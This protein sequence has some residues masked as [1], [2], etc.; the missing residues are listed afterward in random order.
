MNPAPQNPLANAAD[1]S[2]V[3]ATLRLIASLPA[4]QGLEDRIMTTLHAAPCTAR[5]LRWPAQLRQSSG[6]TRA[7]SAAAIVLVVAGVGWGIGSHI[8]PPQP[9]ARGVVAP[10]R[11]AAAA[12]GFSSAGAMRTPQTLNGPV[13]VHPVVVQVVPVK[14]VKKA[15]ARTAPK[16]LNPESP[17]VESSKD[18]A[19][20]AAPSAEP[21]AK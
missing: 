16:K 13:L 12:G 14:P 19:R 20:P 15:V 9:S 18:A 3:D 17:A 10:P 6:W 4:P 7:A 8:Q 11:P 5:I 1:T 21:S 2:T